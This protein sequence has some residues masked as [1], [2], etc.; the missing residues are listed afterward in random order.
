MSE[1][2]WYCKGVMGEYVLNVVEGAI[3]NSINLDQF[4]TSLRRI[5]MNDQEIMNVYAEEV[6]GV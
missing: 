2:K 5:D 3:N 1:V 6:L 4:I